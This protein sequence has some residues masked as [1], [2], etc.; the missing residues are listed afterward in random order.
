M[1]QKP[2][3][4]ANFLRMAGGGIAM[5]EKQISPRRREDAEKTK[6]NQNLCNTEERR[7]RRGRNRRI[8]KQISPR[9][10]GDAEKTKAGE[11][12]TRL[13]TELPWFEE[14]G[15]NYLIINY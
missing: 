7:K 4:P 12:K 2:Y 3:F 15:A 8:E 9:R 14:F 1:A 6:E 5:I 10:R 11:I 13:S